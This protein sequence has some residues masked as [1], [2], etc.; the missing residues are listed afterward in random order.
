MNTT[1]F[2]PI[3]TLLQIV[4]HLYYKIRLPLRS[5]S[6]WRAKQHTDLMWLLPIKTS[7]GLLRYGHKSMSQHRQDLFVL[8]Q[9]NFKRNGFFVEFGATNGI[10]LS[11]SHLLEHEFGWNGILAEPAT[12]WHQALQKNRKCHI[13]TDCVWRDS[14]STLTF[15]E[16]DNPELSTIGEY[17]VA[18]FHHDA[19]KNKR[20]YEVRTISLEDMLVKFGAPHTIDFL[21][22]DTEGSEFEILNSFNFDKYRFNVIICEHNFTPARE[23]IFSLLTQHGYVRKFESLSDVDDWYV[24]VE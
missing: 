6:K 10:A 24:C 23:L 13:E 15:H 4:L 9:L 20:V 14:V 1:H 8:S 19:R 2:N 17:G 16:V 7:I 3:K 18:D 22:I 11:N 12:Y 5:G 21:S